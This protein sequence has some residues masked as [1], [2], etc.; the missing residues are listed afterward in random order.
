LG[1]EEKKGMLA[2]RGHHPLDELVAPPQRL[3][4]SLVVIT[5]CPDLEAEPLKLPPGRGHLRDWVRLCARRLA[6]D[7]VGAPGRV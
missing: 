6:G 4:E 7:A 5:K 1:V 3:A 2:Y